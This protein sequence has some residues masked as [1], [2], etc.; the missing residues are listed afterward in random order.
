MRKQ[1]LCGLPECDCDYTIGSLLGTLEYTTA[2]LRGSLGYLPENVRL[3]VEV[4]VLAANIAIKEAK[5]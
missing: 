2:V 3:S 4:Q 5:G 1:A